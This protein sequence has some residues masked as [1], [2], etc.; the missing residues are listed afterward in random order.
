MPFDPTHIGE[1]TV[2]PLSQLTPDGSWQV[3]LAHDL[4][5]SLLI[6]I[7]RGQGRVFLNGQQ[8]GFGPNSAIFVPV[9]TLWSLEL[10]RQCIG[11][12]MTI[13]A[14]TP[15]DFPES[16]DTLRIPDAQDQAVINSMFQ[17]MQAEQ[18]DRPAL[19]YRAMQAHGTLIAI[20]VRR[21]MAARNSTVSKPT[22]AQRL[23]Q[24]Y[25]GRIVECYAQHASM[26]DHAAALNVT[27]THLTRVCKSETGKTAGALL[28]E[29]QLHAAR[30]LLITSELPMRDIAATLGFGSAAYF[31]RFI[32]Q[33]TGETPSR[34]RKQARDKLKRSA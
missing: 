19:W 21:L 7:T 20:H 3:E 12:V 18:Q 10:G 23:A 13:P 6:W 15:M 32:T 1:I 29:R 5:E 27:P 11:Q 26:A 9:G 33:H 14:S 22:A 2:A 30:S 8:R 24:G 31:T 28:T 25:C 17:A 16:A 4:T 34:L